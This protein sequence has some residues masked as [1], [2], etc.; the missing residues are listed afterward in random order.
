MNH[1]RSPIATLPSLKLKLSVLILTAVAVTVLVFWA[2]TKIGWWPSVSGIIAAT[3]SLALTRWLARG[4]THPLREMAAAADALAA[5]DYHRRVKVDTNDEIGA[6]ANAFNRMAGELA[7]ID[8]LRRDLV[9]NV[10]HE[11]R[12]PIAALHARLENLVDGVEQPT[13]ELL[14]TMLSQVDRLGRLVTRL[15]DLSRLESG[16]IVL[17]HR[18]FSVS[19]LIHQVVQEQQLH[20]PELVVHVDIPAD[21]SLVGD[22]ERIHQVIG[23][24]LENAARHTESAVWIRSRSESATSRHPDV[25]IEIADDGPGIPESDL[26][27]V[28]ERFAR[29][30][31]GRARAVGGAGLG[32]AIAKWIVDLHGGRISAEA[33][34]PHGCRMIV[35]LPRTAA[36]PAVITER[37][38][39]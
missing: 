12:T 31:T 11:L 19:N 33:N 4:L 8:Q 13:A 39:I 24:L 26:E 37:T 35:R 5:G 32:L 34:T 29:T 38:L 21:I 16:A 25:V 30:D 9:A 15:L 23:N 7:A 1:Q 36:Q 6:L 18:Q 2:G 17:E 22:A 20:T 28:F 14:G 3:L 27:L 10:S